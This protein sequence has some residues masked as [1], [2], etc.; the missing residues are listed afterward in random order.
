[1]LRNTSTLFGKAG[2]L[3]KEATKNYLKPF[4][5]SALITQ[6]NA[7]S[8]GVR[9]QENP[10]PLAVFGFIVMAVAAGLAIKDCCSGPS[11]EQMRARGNEAV[12]LADFYSG[13]MRSRGP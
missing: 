9:N 3:A 12:F 1:M 4:V 10:H 8:D 11:E 2:S 5:V 7:D 13:Y 6:V